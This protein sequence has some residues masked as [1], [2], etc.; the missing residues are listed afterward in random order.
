MDAVPPLDPIP[1]SPAA[2]LAALEEQA[3]QYEENVAVAAEPV[4]G[5]PQQPLTYNVRLPLILLTLSCV[6]I[7]I[8][9]CCRWMPSSV[10]MECLGGLDFTPLRRAILAEW[11]TG[12]A[13]MFS[14]LAI[15]LAHEFGHFFMTVIYR[16]RATLPL[17]IPFPLSPLGTLGAVIAMEGGKANRKQIFDIGIAGPLAGLAVAIPV[18][19]VGVMQ[20]DLSPP[21]SGQLAIKPPLLLDWWLQWQHPT[22]WPAA[23]G[24]IWMS[25]CNAF[26]FSGWM[27]LFFTGLNMF[28]VGQLDGGHI[29]YTLLGRG[30]HWL[31]R[32]LMVL[33]F[34]YMT[35]TGN[36]LLL[37]MAVLV[38]LMGTDH[39]PTADDSVPLGPFRTV[40]GWLSL[41]LPI[42]CLRPEA[43]VL[44]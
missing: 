9:G 44:P 28:P 21:P 1:T 25:Q 34:A 7:F 20:L 15:L 22:T 2:D 43:L 4:M 30:A 32:G 13:F 10:L 36:T 11:Q 14:L 23:N 27:G 38:T 6:S 31:S 19:W 29:T 5:D 12:L 16:V 3:V 40:L 8:T 37:L 41:I 24:E 26:L 18:L 17:V 33:A 35:Y 39:P 42:L